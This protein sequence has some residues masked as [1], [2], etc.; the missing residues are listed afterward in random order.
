MT[1]E[2][3]HRAI[4]SNLA[5]VLKRARLRKAGG[6]Q[7]EA[8]DAEPAASSTYVKREQIPGLIQV[9]RQNSAEAQQRSAAAAV[10]RARSGASLGVGC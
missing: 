10:D 7:V 1:H 3:A 2:C 8:A 9:A 6:I 5:A 4:G